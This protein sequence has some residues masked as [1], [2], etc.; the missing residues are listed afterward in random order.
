M[1]VKVLSVF[2]YAGPKSQEWK[3]HKQATTKQASMRFYYIALL[4]VISRIPT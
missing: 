2:E 3:A 1:L 4:G